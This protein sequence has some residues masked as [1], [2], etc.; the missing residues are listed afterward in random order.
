MI[1][2]ILILIVLSGIY[3]YYKYAVTAFTGTDYSKLSLLR[4]KASKTAQKLLL[5]EIA[6]E[7]N[8]SLREA[9]DILYYYDEEIDSY[10]LQKK[11][12]NKFNKYFNTIYKK[13]TNNTK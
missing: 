4:E 9:F 2:I 6:E 1:K 12:I 5:K 8:I 11:Y 13:L 7:K 10:F 3:F